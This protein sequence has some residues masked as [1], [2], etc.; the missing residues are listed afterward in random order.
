MNLRARDCHV[1]GIDDNLSLLSQQKV[2]NELPS[3]STLSEPFKATLQLVVEST[4][5]WDWLVDGL[6]EAG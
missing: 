4:F 1:C 6:Q 5:N 3:I 2:R